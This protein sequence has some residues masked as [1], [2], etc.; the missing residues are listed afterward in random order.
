MPAQASM[1]LNTKVYTPRGTSN[2]IST[3][4]L[5]GDSTFGGAQS[6]ATESVRG[7]RAD[8]TYQ[9]QWQ[10]VVPKAAAADSACSCTGEILGVGKAKI[11]LVWPVAF[12][13]AEKQDFVDRVQAMVATTVFDVS[14]SIPEGTWS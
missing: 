14:V 4:A 9:T 10:L 6:Q 8:G 13:S 12:T 5:A 3:W 11:D 7:P 1:T 2:G